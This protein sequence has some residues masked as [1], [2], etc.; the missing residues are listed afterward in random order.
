MV[1]QKNPTGKFWVWNCQFIEATIASSLSAILLLCS[2]LVWSI[3]HFHQ[4]YQCL[5]LCKLQISSN[6]CCCKCCISTRN[7]LAFSVIAISPNQGWQ[8]SFIEN[9]IKSRLQ[10]ITFLIK[11]WYQLI[12]TLWH[13]KI[14]FIVVSLQ[15]IKIIWIFSDDLVNFFCFGNIYFLNSH[16]ILK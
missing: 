3:S 1:K 7:K 9:V 12:F 11:N 2:I 16:N 13:I 15:W 6:N 14:A 5:F 8:S 4:A 10:L